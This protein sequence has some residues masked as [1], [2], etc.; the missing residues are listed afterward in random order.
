MPSSACLPSCKRRH[1]G[2]PDLD[3]GLSIA[4]LN[5]QRYREIADRLR[6]R[7]DRGELFDSG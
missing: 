7:E 6:V 5:A 2:T 4:V 3:L 1:A